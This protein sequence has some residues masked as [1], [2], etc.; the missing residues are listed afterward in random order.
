MWSGLI[1]DI[2]NGWV[3]CDGENGTPDLRDRFVVGAPDGVNPGDIGGFADHDHDMTFDTDL[4]SDD[5]SHNFSTTT[6]AVNPGSYDV[7]FIG[8][9]KELYYSHTHYLQGTTDPQDTNH[10]HHVEETTDVES[11]LPP[12]YKILFIM[13]T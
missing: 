9:S 1:V 13:K 8:G 12:Y 5:H 2:P 10:H 6:Y 7:D 3:L 11:H 4:Q